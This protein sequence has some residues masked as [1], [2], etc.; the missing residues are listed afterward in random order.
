MTN[1]TTNS[2]VMT[3]CYKIKHTKQMSLFTEEQ[4]NSMRPDKAPKRVFCMVKARDGHSWIQ[5]LD[6]QPGESAYRAAM[7]YKYTM[8]GCRKGQYNYYWIESWWEE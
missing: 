4:L 7:R 3:E 2:S 5:E 8:L 6:R 1:S